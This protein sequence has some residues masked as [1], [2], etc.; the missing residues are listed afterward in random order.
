MYRAASTGNPNKA[1][2]ES[3][4]HDSNVTSPHGYKS[5]NGVLLRTN[6]GKQG[7][8]TVS[9]CYY[10]LILASI[11]WLDSINF[12][13]DTRYKKCIGTLVGSGNGFL[14]PMLDILTNY[15]HYCFQVDMYSLS[16]VQDELNF[17][18]CEFFRIDMTLAYGVN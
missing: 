6:C 16:L 1:R 14:F 9:Y 7:K 8:F 12:K 17:N 18:A 10:N 15:D 13:D 11:G 5:I 2:N 3:H 4:N